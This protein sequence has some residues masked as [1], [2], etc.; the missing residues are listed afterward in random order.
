M[1]FFWHLLFASALALLL[2]TLL[3]RNPSKLVFFTTTSAGVLPDLDHL[4]IWTPELLTRLFPTYLWEGLTFSI[5][6]EV[7]PLILHLWIWPLALCLTGILLRGKKYQPYL[8][9][10]AAGWMLHL[11]LDGTFI[12]I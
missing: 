12:L 1:Y 8:L 4:P 6:T 10:G 11:A 7:Y 2:S 9:A 3:K 5:R